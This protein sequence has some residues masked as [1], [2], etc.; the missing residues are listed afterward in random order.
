MLPEGGQLRNVQQGDGMIF[1]VNLRQLQ[2]ILQ[3]DMFRLN[4]KNSI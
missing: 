1:Y 2:E 4:G 3:N